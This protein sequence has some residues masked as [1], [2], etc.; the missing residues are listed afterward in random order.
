MKVKETIEVFLTFESIS[1]TTFQ[2]SANGTCLA[3]KAFTDSLQHS[4]TLVLYSVGPPQYLLCSNT[5]TLPAQTR[6]MQLL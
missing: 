1:G 6:S 5:V 2:S 4:S 3:T